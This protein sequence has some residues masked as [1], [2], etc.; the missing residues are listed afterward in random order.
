VKLFANIYLALRVSPFK[1][2]D[3]Y[4]EMKGMNTRQNINDACM[5]PRIGTYY[6]NPRFGYGGYYMP[7]DTKQ[8][9]MNYANLMQ[10]MTT[11]IVRSNRI[12]KDF[13]DEVCWRSPMHM[14]QKRKY[15]Q[16]TFF[17]KIKWSY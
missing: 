4:A 14:R 3:I 6:N 5:D 9:L 13:I 10:N 12:L 11:A 16:E 2:T 8:L 17:R 1:E 15:I 7:K